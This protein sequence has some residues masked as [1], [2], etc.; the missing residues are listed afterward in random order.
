MTAC[1]AALLLLLLLQCPHRLAALSEGRIEA[2]G[3]L[4]CAYHDWR[5]DGGGSCVRIPQQLRRKQQQ[6]G[7]EEEEEIE[8]L[9]V[10]R[11][12]SSS[13]LDCV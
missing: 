5:F 1:T 8:A 12:R 7:D 13:I 9:V 2:N 11:R 3:T 4:A 10:R 6:R